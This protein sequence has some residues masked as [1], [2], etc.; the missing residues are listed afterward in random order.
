[1][2]VFVSGAGG[3]L[4]RAVTAE[5]VKRGHE[6]VGL[7]RTEEKG[8]IIKNLGA[9]YIIGDLAREGPWKEEVQSSYRVVSLSWP[10]KFTELHTIEE[11]TELNLRHAKGVVNLIRAARHGETRAILVTYDTLCLGD[12]ADKWI[13]EPGAIKPAGFCRPIG[14]AYDEITRAGKE[15][16]IPLI[17]VF[18]ARVY[19]QEGWFPYL[20][21][22]IQKGEW[23]TAGN[24]DNYISLIHVRDL[25]RAYGEA[26]E[27]LTHGESLTLADGRPTTQAEFTDFIA[28][29]LG[30]SRPGRMTIHEFAE[31]EGIML[32]ESFATSA[33]VSGEKAAR[34]L[35]FIPEFPDYHSGVMDVLKT[36]G[37]TPRVQKAA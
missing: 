17:N 10:V 31:K 37:I 30:V 11:M 24:G 12:K 29:I 33:R 14:N 22:R 35:D 20:T 8:R 13:D 1:M 4:G 28:D 9:R 23:K 18:P 16:N 36:M 15:A 27:R 25:A 6:V 7:V 32:A 26:V 34:L 3:F 5:L 21:L 2:K 19:G